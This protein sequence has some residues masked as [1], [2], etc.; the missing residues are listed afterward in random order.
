MLFRATALLS[1]ASLALATEPK[2]LRTTADVYEEEPPAAATLYY[3]RKY[4]DSGDDVE[5]KGAFSV[6]KGGKCSGGFDEEKGGMSKHCE[7]GMKK[8]FSMKLSGQEMNADLG[9]ELMEQFQGFMPE[10]NNLG[11]SDEELEVLFMNEDGELDLSKTIEFG[12]SIKV[13]WGCKMAFEKKGKGFSKKVECG[14]KADSS[15][16]KKKDGEASVL[17]YFN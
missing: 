17:E 8:E 11:L 3:D 15:A 13:E 5:K 6:E 1:L 12:G 2:L 10:S 14:A 7:G 16:G 9:S 4:E